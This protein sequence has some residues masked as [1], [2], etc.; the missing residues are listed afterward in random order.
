MVSYENHVLV[1][2]FTYSGNSL[3]QTAFNLNLIHTKFLSLVFKNY[4]TF[5]KKNHQYI[6]KG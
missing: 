6:A 1:I 3:N 5:L 2:Y 4:Y